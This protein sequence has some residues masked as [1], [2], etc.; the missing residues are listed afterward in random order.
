MVPKISI[1]MPVHNRERYVGAAI[2]S[3]LS[4]TM[5]DFELLVWNDAS[6]DRSLEIARHYA[7]AD[8]RVRVVS[9]ERQGVA[10]VS[11]AAF[12]ITTGAYV[13]VVD[14]D[15]LL[16]PTALEE[17]SAILNAHPN[18]GLVYTDY[19]MINENGQDLGLGLR[20]QIPYSKNRQLVDFMT[21]H[22]RLIR[23]CAYDQIGGVDESFDLASDCDLCL[24]LSEVTQVHHIH[25]PLYYY[26]KHGENISNQKQKAIQ[27][28]YRA[29]L[30]ALKRRGLDKHYQLDLREDGKSVLRHKQ[31][32]AK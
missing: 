18:V 28:G 4:Q 13:G 20:C 26:R 11:K 19:R 12:S 5:C 8:Q 7:E 10:P 25:K 23:R 1:V 32:L 3:V 21:F 6:S 15:D 16:A 17:T 9:A 2:E 27:W 14:S 30:K 24:R 22:F 31:G 29:S